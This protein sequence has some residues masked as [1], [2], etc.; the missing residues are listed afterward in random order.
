MIITRRSI[1]NAFNQD[2]RYDEALER[3]L[4]EAQEE[5]Q[6]ILRRNGLRN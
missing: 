2:G 4:R 6:E 5:R 3:I 1:A